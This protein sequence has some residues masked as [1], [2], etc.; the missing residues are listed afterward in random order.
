MLY[1]RA[2][3]EPLQHRD[4]D[5]AAARRMIERIVRDCEERFSPE[6]HWPVHPL[7]VEDAKREPCSISTSAPA[8]SSG[9]CTIW[10][11]LARSS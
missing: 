6:L 8:G 5:E 2:R 4:W 9:R 10:R 7:Y 11:S 3:H 1:V